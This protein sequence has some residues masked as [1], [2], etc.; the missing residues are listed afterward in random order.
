[1][2]P[3]RNFVCNTL[4]FVEVLASPGWLRYALKPWGSPSKGL[5]QWEVRSGHVIVLKP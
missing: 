1:M 5:Y 4:L 3:N 2:R